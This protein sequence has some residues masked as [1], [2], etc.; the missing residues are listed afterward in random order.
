MQLR[1]KEAFFSELVICPPC[2]KATATLHI[3]MWSIL[4]PVAVKLKSCAMPQPKTQLWDFLMLARS[5]R[6][7]TELSELA[8][9]GSCIDAPVNAS[10]PVP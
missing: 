3:F 5:E 10:N 9:L 1:V 4:S 2:R 7:V 6:F 8:R